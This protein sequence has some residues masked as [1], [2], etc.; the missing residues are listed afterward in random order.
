MVR[1]TIATWC[2]RTGRS[3]G[4]TLGCELKVDVSD[5]SI[6]TS[7][8]KPDTERWAWDKNLYKNGN[9]FVE[10]YA[11][12]IKPRVTVGEEI[13]ES[14]EVDVTE[15]D[16]GEETDSNAHTQ[17][18]SSAKYHEIIRADKIS[19]LMNPREQW[20]L[21]VYAVIALCVLMLGN[22]FISLSAAGLI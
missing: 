20:R 18:I 8:V 17:L 4:R 9:L 16:G 14:T 7:M 6:K 5:H 12:P 3:I 1:E 11:N 10:E 22:V 13:D 21:I 19:Q 15:G 2:V